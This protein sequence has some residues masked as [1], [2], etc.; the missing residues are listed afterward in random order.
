MLGMDMLIK[1]M[2]LDPEKIQKDIA[3]ASAFAQEQVKTV[4]D[5]LDR[6]EGNQLLLYQLLL[7]A[8]VIESVTA[9]NESKQAEDM[10]AIENGQSK[11]N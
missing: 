7:R 3:A 8:G 2:G 10:R 6:I 5:Q 9:Y 4:R 11:I 1:S